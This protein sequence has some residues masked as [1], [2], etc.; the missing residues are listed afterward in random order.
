MASAPAPIDIA[1]IGERRAD[2]VGAWHP[3]APSRRF[4]CGYPSGCDFGWIGNKRSKARWN[5]PGQADAGVEAD[6]GIPGTDQ[7]ATELIVA[8]ERVG[9]AGDVLLHSRR[10]YDVAFVRLRLRGLAGSVET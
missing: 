6:A 10:I 3:K 4:K 7:Q 9:V 2:G 1:G 5:L 8:G